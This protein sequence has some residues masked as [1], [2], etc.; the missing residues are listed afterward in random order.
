MEK[1]KNILICP[2]EWGLGHATRMIPVASELLRH[3]HNVIFASGKEHLSLI[4]N[5]LPECGFLSFPGFKPGY[6]RYLPQYISI[7]LKLPLLLY[8]IALEHIRLSKIIRKYSID[9]VISDN[10]FGLW[11]RNVKTVYVTHMLLIPFPGKMKFLE[12]AGAFIHRQIIKRYDFCFIPDLP[13]GNNL[14]GRLSHGM[15]IPRNVRYIGILSR[16][17]NPQTPQGVPIAPDSYRDGIGVDLRKQTFET[18]S[19]DFKY[20]IVILSGPEPQKEILKQKLISIFKDRDPVTIILEGKPGESMETGR[21]GNIILYSHLSSVDMRKTILN[22]EG[23]ISRSGYTTVMDLM[24]LNCSA[25]LIPT[26]GQTEQ[27][28]LA[29]YLTGQGLFLNILQKDLKSGVQFPPKESLNTSDL[30]EE[31]RKLLT[32]ALRELSEE[33]HHETKAKKT[34]KKS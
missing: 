30:I 26:P 25:L 3:N 10:R 1:P 5:E 31:S 16:F 17:I 15:I 18:S 29:E 7:L 4:R 2:I 33:P 9:I 6:S 20:N 27:E 22:S 28:Y 21:I 11:N 24:S 34:Q 12:P 8:H 19:P 32:L 23:I 14:S 13:G